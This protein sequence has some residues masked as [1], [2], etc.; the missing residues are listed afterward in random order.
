MSGTASMVK[1]Y[2]DAAELAA[3]STSLVMGKVTSA[4]SVVIADL[5]ATRY[6]L[7]VETVLAG[8]ASGEITV[9]MFGEPGESSTVEVPAF[10]TT[11]Q[12]YTL[13]LRPTDLPEGT[14]GADGFY[15]VG[16]GAWGE[17][18]ESRFAIWLDEPERFDVVDIPLEF[19]LA[20]AAE[21]LAA[22]RVGSGR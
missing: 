4:S 16:L 3:D 14:V 11:G 6:V 17:V 20:D 7:A 2:H 10:F 19:T 9:Y 15:I 5:G 8:S 22:D 21:L 18:S 13:F 12:R 1:R